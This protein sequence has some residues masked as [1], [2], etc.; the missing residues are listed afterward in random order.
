MGK[1]ARI[2]D[3]LSTRGI[4]DRGNMGMRLEGSGLLLLLLL[5][6]AFSVLPLLF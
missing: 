1:G 4:D 5:A 6:S 3:W 2:L